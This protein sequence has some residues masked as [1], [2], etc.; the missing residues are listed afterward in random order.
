MS[1]ALISHLNTTF[2]SEVAGSIGIGHRWSVMQYV[3]DWEMFF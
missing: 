2:A 3:P 1:Q